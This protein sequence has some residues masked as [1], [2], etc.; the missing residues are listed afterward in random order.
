MYQFSLL[1]KQSDVIQVKE[2]SEFSLQ[3]FEVNFFYHSFSFAL[4][5][6]YQ[7]REEY[8]T[9]DIVE[10]KKK[11][12]KISVQS[13]KNERKKKKYIFWFLTRK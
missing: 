9:T 4:K 10:R 8:E 5:T 12:L 13:E 11:P 3:K 2:K 7:G 1:Y 6:V